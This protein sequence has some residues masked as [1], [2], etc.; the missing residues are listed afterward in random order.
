M[1]ADAAGNLYGTTSKGGDWN[2]GS[3]FKL[4]PGRN[5]TWKHTV[6]YSFNPNTWDGC[7]PTAGVVIDAAGHLYG[8]TN[9]GGDFTYGV[10]YEI[11]P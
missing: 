4:A 7:Y 8:T 9:Y 11:I 10:V 1:T 6:I 5:N 2:C 3:V